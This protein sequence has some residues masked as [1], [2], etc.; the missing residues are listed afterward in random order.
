MWSHYSDSMALLRMREVPRWGEDI[1]GKNMSYTAGAHDSMLLD[2]IRCEAFRSAIA[3]AAPGRRVL[4]VGAGPFLL[5]GRLSQRSGASFVACV[6]H[7]RKSITL[8]LEM[9]KREVNEQLASTGHGCW[10]VDEDL[11]EECEQHLRLLGQLGV[12]LSLGQ[13]RCPDVSACVA[14]AHTAGADVDKGNEGPAADSGVV[15]AL[16]HGISS[17]VALPGNIELVV[18]EILGHIASAEGV[19]KAIRELRTRAGLLAPGCKMVPRAAGTLIAPTSPLPAVPH[20]RPYRGPPIQGA[21]LAA[22]LADD[23]LRTMPLPARL[24]RLQQERG[25]GR[26]NVTP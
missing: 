5:L 22:T 24:Y 21:G 19:V 10:S 26:S 3:L 4:D 6:E 14:V 1:N 12:R 7:S 15:V 16:Y 18:H 8:A 13:L 23:G 11:D 25:V 9:L 17:S 20:C 2:T